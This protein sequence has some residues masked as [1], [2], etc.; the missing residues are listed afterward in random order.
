MK[1]R[2]IVVAAIKEQKVDV[3]RHSSQ[4][5]FGDYVAEDICKCRFTYGIMVNMAKSERGISIIFFIH[6]TAK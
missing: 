3:D 2:T 5:W 4:V 1:V 6:W